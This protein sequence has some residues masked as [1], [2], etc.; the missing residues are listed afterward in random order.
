MCWIFAEDLG[1]K[2]G[3]WLPA[4]ALAAV[5]AVRQQAGVAVHSYTR[6]SYRHT[7]ILLRLGTDK[8]R[9]FVRTV[10]GVDMR[11]DIHTDKQSTQQ[12]VSVFQKAH[13]GRK[14]AT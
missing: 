10:C 1:R 9:V 2:F 5:S 6:T 14:T 3:H 13:T 7:G 11:L 4:L 12:G 8:H